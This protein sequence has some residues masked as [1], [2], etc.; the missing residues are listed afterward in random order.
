[1][2]LDE[3]VS[4]TTAALVAM[5]MQVGVYIAED[6]TA[7]RLRVYVGLTQGEP[8]SPTLYNL[9]GD[10]LLEGMTDASRLF[11]VCSTNDDK[12]ARGTGERNEDNPRIGALCH[13]ATN[14]DSIC[15]RYI[16]PDA[17]VLKGQIALDACAL[18]ARKNGMHWILG[19]SFVMLQPGVCLPAGGF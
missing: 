10:C 2:I 8:S 7:L 6:R 9:Y 13:I 12:Q 5:L 15:G 11:S 14:G 17:V 3:R 4:A 1:M 16:V 18:W 19:K